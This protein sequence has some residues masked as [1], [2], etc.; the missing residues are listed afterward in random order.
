MSS[1]WKLHVRQAAG[2]P[3]CAPSTAFSTSL[4]F[5]FSIYSAANIVS[6]SNR[7]SEDFPELPECEAIRPKPVRAQQLLH[8]PAADRLRRDRKSDRRPLLVSR[9]VRR[10]RATDSGTG[11]RILRRAAS[12]RPF[13]LK[14]R[15]L[16]FPPASLRI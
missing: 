2:C 4:G 5:T 1:A 13:S 11:P 14:E 12:P 16:S 10:V 7:L 3:A 6:I 15:K 9:L 8:R